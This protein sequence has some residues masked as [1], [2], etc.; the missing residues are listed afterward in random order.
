MIDE[1]HIMKC[2]FIENKKAGGKKEVKLKIH[3]VV[4]ISGIRAGEKSENKKR[5]SNPRNEKHNKKRGERER[6][7]EDQGKCVLSDMEI[8]VSKIISI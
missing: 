5:L 8:W 6:E 3:T 4:H 1:I 2:F 7:E